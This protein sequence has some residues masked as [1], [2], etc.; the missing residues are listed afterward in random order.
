MK[1]TPKPRGRAGVC[2]VVVFLCVICGATPDV[3]RRRPDVLM[4]RPININAD[5]D[6]D[7]LSFETYTYFRMFE[8]STG[9]RRWEWPL[10]K[11]GERWQT[12]TGK[13]LCLVY[14]SQEVVVLDKLTGREVVVL[15]ERNAGGLE[16]AC[17][18][19]CTDWI[20]CRFQNK[21]VLYPPGQ[22]QGYILPKSDNYTG[23]VSSPDRA[24]VYVAYKEEDNPASPQD[25]NQIQR[26]RF[27]HGV[28]GIGNN[29]PIFTIESEGQLILRK[30]TSSGEMLL[31]ALYGDEKEPTRKH[32]LRDAHTG[33]LILEADYDSST[34][35]LGYMDKTSRF[36]VMDFERKTA[37]GVDAHT[38]ETV[39]TLH[40]EGHVFEPTFYEDD[41]G[42]AWLLS[43]DL[44]GNIWL[45]P[46][47]KNARPRKILTGDSFLPGSVKHLMPP[48]LLSCN[49]DLKSPWRVMHLDT[50]ETVAEYNMESC[51]G[52]A[53]LNNDATRVMI[54][55]Y[56]GPS[57]SE[58]ARNQA[59]IY[60][61]TQQ[62]ALLA[63]PLE[64]RAFS[65]DGRAV[66]VQPVSPVSTKDMKPGEWRALYERADKTVTVVDVDSGSVLV[67][68]PAD[69]FYSPAAFSRD[70]TRVAVNNR[71]AL[72]IVHLAADNRLVQ[73]NAEP[74]GAW[75]G[76]LCFSPDGALLLA[77]ARGQ[78]TLFDAETGDCLHT[79]KERQKF[80]PR[81]RQAEKDQDFLTW[82]EYAARD[83]AS[84]FTDRFHYLPLLEGAFCDDGRCLVTVAE[85]QLLRVWNTRTGSLL[86]TINPKLPEKRSSYGSINNIIAPSRNGNYAIAYNENGFCDGSLW[87]VNTGELIRRYSFKDANRIN[88]CVS[89]DGKTVYAL[90]DGDLYFLTGVEEE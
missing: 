18:V 88:A 16:Y 17:F 81:H 49:S 76:S 46:F 14:S 60:C 52:Q 27:Y 90:L 19:G 9:R 79:L 20:M 87:N 54:N 21:T 2:A 75:F 7:T 11:K 6:L 73:C 35:C 80:A 51:S 66:V 71:P 43:R 39:V 69:S 89:D 53:L 15:R 61:A 83:L 45:W 58:T 3:S 63:M 5:V 28:P 72:T 55:R 4:G 74:R 26:Y 1:S 24:D 85:G 84:T 42:Q 77:A 44:D 65:P 29:T 57:E 59:L 10:Y 33:D 12:K 64:G 36:V 32:Q 56:H 23:V 62:Q 25:E 30:T 68:L 40:L 8:L 70:G 48:Y 31:V 82:M 13:R 47:E 22:S 41:L 86:R 78:A 50:R 67:S 34:L 37:R 38:G